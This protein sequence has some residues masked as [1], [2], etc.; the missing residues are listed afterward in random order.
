MNTDEARGQII[1][2][3][4]YKGGTGRSMAL[5]NIACLLAE[6]QVAAGGK[7]VLMI[8]WDLEAPGLHRYFAKRL[9]T[10]RLGIESLN[11]RDAHNSLPGL[12]DL[13]Y[14][15]EKQVDMSATDGSGTT[16]QAAREAIARVKLSDFI[17]ST[18]ISGLSLLKAGRFM[19]PAMRSTVTQ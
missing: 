5:A 16:E 12:I 14:E 15:F 3:Y 18:S 8:D 1:T 13:F 11:R 17:L 10:T 4:S 9:T 19:T 6:Q 7:G 2:F